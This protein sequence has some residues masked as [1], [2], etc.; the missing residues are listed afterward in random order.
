[1]EWLNQENINSD[2][3]R[4]SCGDS[5]AE[6]EARQGPEE[7]RWRAKQIHLSPWIQLLPKAFGST[8]G[9]SSDKETDSFF[10]L[11]E[12]EYS[13]CHWKQE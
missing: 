12:S 9:V 4:L 8:L 1:M 5:S 10:C 13:F 3:L 2:C 6:N 11:R 7:P